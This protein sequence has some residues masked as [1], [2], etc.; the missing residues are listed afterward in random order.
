MSGGAFYT[1]LAV[2]V[3]SGTPA[4]EPLPLTDN[5]TAPASG[6][7]KLRLVHA[8]AK[9][10]GTNGA[11]DVYITAPGADISG[12]SAS[13]SGFKYKGASPYKEVAAGDYQVRITLP[14]TKTVAI[15]TGKATLAAGKIYTGIA[16]DTTGST[17][18]AVLLTD[19]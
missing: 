5:N 17:F 2:G 3:L 4:L 18:Q 10:P 6:K 11:V 14:G 16:L 7:A 15:D 1:V 13:I 12:V 8:A 19:N 9:V